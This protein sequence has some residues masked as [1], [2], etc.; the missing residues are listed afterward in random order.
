MR[1][2][3]LPLNTL[4]QLMTIPVAERTSSRIRYGSGMRVFQKS[5][6]YPILM[7]SAVNRSIKS[8][9]KMVVNTHK[10][11]INSSVIC[12]GDCIRVSMLFYSKLIKP[13]RDEAEVP[14]FVDMHIYRIVIKPSLTHLDK[15]I[16]T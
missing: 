4:R 10:E 1:R 6:I 8:I 15:I 13:R 9:K 16:T 5:G 3:V 7:G 2:R 14:L 12:W 11:M